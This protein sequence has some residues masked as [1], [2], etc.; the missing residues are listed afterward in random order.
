MAFGGCKLGDSAFL[1]RCRNQALGLPRQPT[2]TSVHPVSRFSCSPHSNAVRGDGLLPFGRFYSLIR[3][4]SWA[5]LT[6][7]NVEKA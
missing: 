4:K 6:Q 2:G 7:R 5:W 3:A 1:T